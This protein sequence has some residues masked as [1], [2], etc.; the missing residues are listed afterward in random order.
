M[1]ADAAKLLAAALVQP[2]WAKGALN[3]MLLMIGASAKHK[4]E[5]L[6]A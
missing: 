4:R 3:A 2:H 1:E 5:L 6:Y